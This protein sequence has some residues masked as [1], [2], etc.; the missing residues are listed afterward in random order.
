MAQGLQVFD[1]EGNS[2]SNDFSGIINIV[3]VSD[4]YYSG[5][6]CGGDMSENYIFT[7][8]SGGEI[9][10][11][12]KTET[13]ERAVHS[14]SGTIIT[15]YLVKP[16][17]KMLKNNAFLFFVKGVIYKVAFN[18]KESDF[19]R[20]IRVNDEKI[21]GAINLDTY[22]QDLHVEIRSIEW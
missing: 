7:W 4:N 9:T 21:L 15:R 2:F 8:Y 12:S 5:S 14:D 10:I 6:S 3:P 13:W 11:N 22:D 16:K 18:V 20:C 17:P 19:D 1:A